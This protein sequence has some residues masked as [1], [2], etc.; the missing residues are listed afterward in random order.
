MK[1]PICSAEMECRSPIRN[2]VYAD[3]H[4]FNSTCATQK[5]SYR[6]HIEVVMINGK[7][8]WR[9]IAYHLPFQDW[10][11]SWLIIEGNENNKETTLFDRTSYLM[12]EKKFV[13][14]T[15]SSAVK[16]TMAMWEMTILV[17]V[18]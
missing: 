2:K 1:C 4:C 18:N 11:N 17:N 6:P 5:I 8:P 7:A 13:E 9:C 12:S 16:D 14:N 15:N 10:D 3:F